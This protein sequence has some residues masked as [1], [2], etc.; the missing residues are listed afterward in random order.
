[1]KRT[2]GRKTLPW[3]MDAPERQMKINAQNPREWLSRNYSKLGS[4]ISRLSMS[5]MADRD[6]DLIQEM[7]S[8]YNMNGCMFMAKLHDCNPQRNDKF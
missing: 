6:H 4:I 5:V 7:K 3:H 2:Q 1:M 8:E